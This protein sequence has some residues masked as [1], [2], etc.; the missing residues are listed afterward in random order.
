VFSNYSYKETGD[1]IF[2]AATED[3]SVVVTYSSWVLGK[4]G[5]IHLSTHQSYIWQENSFLMQPHN[6]TPELEK[7][8]KRANAWLYGMKW[9]VWSELK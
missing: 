7:M 4:A 6:L 2:D 8:R 3:D 9:Q 1:N 5:C